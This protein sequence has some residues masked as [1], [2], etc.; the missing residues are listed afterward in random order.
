MWDV[1]EQLSVPPGV[2]AQAAGLVTLALSQRQGRTR[3]RGEI[4]IGF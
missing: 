3:F 4:T 2:S 1:R